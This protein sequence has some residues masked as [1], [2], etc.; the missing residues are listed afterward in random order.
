LIII[1]AYAVIALL[2]GESAMD[3]VAQILRSNDPV[4][5]TT[6]S[7]AEVLDQMVRS[8][9]I[10]PDSLRVDLAELPLHSTIAFDAE[11]SEMAGTLRA[12]HYHR[13]RCAVSLE[14]C[15]V[16]AAALELDAVIA[17]ANPHLLEV[18]SKMGVATVVLP[19]TAG[20]RWQPTV[21]GVQRKSG[22]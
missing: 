13:T 2:I 11:M 20:N 5:M 1:D 9:G 10:N 14:D 8:K 17:S 21:S 16:L 15:S 3:E 12:S 18:A 19:D 7:R 4:A 22:R 6:L